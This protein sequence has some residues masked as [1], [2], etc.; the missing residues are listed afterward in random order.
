MNKSEH[1]GPPRGF[2]YVTEALR[3]EDFPMGRHE[4]DYCVG[5]VEVED[6]H[7]GYAPVRNLT[8]RFG[9]KL[10]GNAEEVIKVLHEAV[11]HRRKRAA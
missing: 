4:I 2:R 7:G 6:G 1:K 8:D 5:D 3:L 10:F 11:A 9:D